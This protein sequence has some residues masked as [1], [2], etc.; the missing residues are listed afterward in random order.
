[1]HKRS[2]IDLITAIQAGG[3][4]RAAAWKYMYNSW[5]GYYLKPVLNKGGKPDEVDDIMGRVF[6]DVDV[7]LCKP[8]FELKGATLATYFSTAVYRSWAKKKQSEQSKPVLL[9]EEYAATISS[10]DNPERRM[11]MKEALK[12]VEGMKEPCRT[13]LIQKGEGYSNEEISEALNF[14]VQHVKNMAV[15]CK[16]KLINLIGGNKYY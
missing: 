13:I 9:P 6:Q 2:D 7:Q 5:R 8:D 1:M 11:I 4:Q 14:S 15:E 10:S 12:K 16:K 3:Q